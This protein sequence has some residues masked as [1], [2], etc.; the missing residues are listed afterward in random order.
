MK[1]IN[2]VYRDWGQKIAAILRD[3]SLSG[4]QLTFTTQQYFER[5]LLE[6]SAAIGDALRTEIPSL[7]NSV[8]E[9]SIAIETEFMVDAWGDLG[10][11]LTADGLESMFRLATTRA[12]AT[13]LSAPFKGE[14]FLARVPNISKNFSDDVVSLVQA[15]IAQGRDLGK[16]AADVNVF[17]KDGK[18]FTIK[19]WGEILEPGSSALLKRIRFDKV[20]YRAL[21]LARTELG[22]ALEKT[23]LNNGPMN[24]GAFDLYD[25][26]RVNA[27]DW[28]CVCPDNAANGPYTRDEYPG[29]RHP[30]CFCYPRVR[31][32][33]GREFRDQLKRWAN[34]ESVPEIDAW[35]RSKY[36]PALGA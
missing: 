35:Y 21:R 5:A 6:A 8:G 12:I 28:G 32:K 20:D 1:R 34:G 23:A 14:T 18:A 36:L 19:R 31:L 25:W 22:R 13:S 17:V 4:S 33:D 10:S 15:A 9:L 16:I 2:A 27:I 30:N 26:V 24:P 29:D 11:R 7:I 3:G